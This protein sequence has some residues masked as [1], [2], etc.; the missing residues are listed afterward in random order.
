M[1][2][3]TYKGLKGLLVNKSRLSNVG[4]LLVEKSFDHTS[5]YDIIEKN[6]YIADDDSEYTNLRKN[7][8]TWLESPTFLDIVDLRLEHNPS[9]S[10]DE[11]VDAIIYY[12]EN[13]AFME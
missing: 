4:W 10:D 2:V 6:F 7:Y 1:T 11:I 12:L 5:R 8:S 9:A 13:D 3:K